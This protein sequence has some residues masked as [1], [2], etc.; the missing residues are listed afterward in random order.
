MVKFID[1]VLE[2][3]DKVCEIGI[4]L[5]DSLPPVV[6]VE[7]NLGIRK[8]CLKPLF[9][10]AL[11][12]LYTLKLQ[13]DPDGKCPKYIGEVLSISRIV[14][15]VKGDFPVAYEMRKK[16]IQ[17]GLCNVSIEIPLTSL[18]FT[19][20]PKCP[21]GWQHRRWCIAHRKSEGLLNG[22]SC[23]EIESERELCKDMAEKHPK[24]YY[25]WVHRLWLIQF[26]QPVQVTFK[27]FK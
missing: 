24:N 16:L 10:Y 11:T 19:R 21:S 14:L 6:F 2:G 9:L 5:D 13:Y 15:I 7:G 20:H 4:T 8:D 3:A 18:I 27:T 1:G 17:R 22:L 26:M 25:A 12:K 23:S